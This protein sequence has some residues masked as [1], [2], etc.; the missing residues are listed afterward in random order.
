[1]FAIFARIIA[2]MT[3]YI[4][5]VAKAFT[6]LGQGPLRGV[7]TGV[8][9]L[10]GVWFT[11]KLFLAPIEAAV[12]GVHNLIGVLGRAESSMRNLLH[13]GLK[14]KIGGLFGKATGG[15]EMGGIAKL[16][17]LDANTAA[18]NRLTLVLEKWGGASSVASDIPGGAGIAKEGGIFSRFAKSGIGSKLG[19]VGSKMM[20]LA[21][22]GG[23]VAEGGVLAEGGA[24]A[25]MG[26]VLLPL[27]P[28]IAG[29]AAAAAAAYLI[30]K[31]WRGILTGLKDVFN[32]LKRAFD[33]V[34][35]FIKSHWKLLGMILLA[36][37]T[38]F[39]II[40]ETIKNH[41]RGLWTGMKAVMMPVVNFFEDMWNTEV[42]LVETVVKTI[43]KSWD[44]V[45]GFIKGIGH[46]IASFAKSIWTPLY[47][48]FIAVAN[49]II[50]AYDDTIGWMPGM[51]IN[52]LHS[53]G[54]GTGS[55]QHHAA[56][57]RAAS[58]A[59]MRT[60]GAAGSG[61]VMN[62]HQGAVQINIHGN[63][64]EKTLKVVKSEINKNL[65]E[66]HRVLKGRGR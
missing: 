2:D 53:L 34:W 5:E 18:L 29:I 4:T 31:H 66:F 32:F 62:V 27:L 14:S 63:P 49:M 23:M 21:G 22:M 38:P 51:H 35:G 33:D 57:A 65:T 3:P 1:M 28:I 24:L 64:D 61:P 60:H 10:A 56:N 58:S 54:G 47:N 13:G 44:G 26:T 17:P 48:G 52:T 41:W 59:M 20:G 39:L 40:I 25:G 11:R 6:S 9:I 7:I 45:W 50:R 37:F 42:S 46:D 30:F 8:G 55:P 12:G 15:G 19:G 16:E 43:E 36:P